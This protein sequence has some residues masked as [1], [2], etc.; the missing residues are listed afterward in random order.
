MMA[1]KTS[2]TSAEAM[3]CAFPHAMALCRTEAD[4]P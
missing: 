4:E 2:M 1:K 3:H